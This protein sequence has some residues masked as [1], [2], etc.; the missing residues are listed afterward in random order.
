M[1]II[2]TTQDFI[3]WRSTVKQS[4][5]FVPTMGNLHEGHMSLLEASLQ[6]HPVSVLSVFV[7]PKQFNESSDFQRYPRT[8]EQD[9]ALCAALL[10]QHKGRDLVI[11]APADPSEIYPPG[12]ASVVSVPTLG[13][14]FEGEFRPGHFEGMATVVYLLLHT[15]RPQAAYFGRKDYQQYRIVKRM[16]RDLGLPVHI[17][18]MPI[19][20]AEDG[21]ALSSRNQFLKG[22]ERSEALKL[23][24]TLQHLAR[25]IAGSSA[26][27]ER[28]SAHAREVMSSDSR[29][30]YLAIR[31]ARHLSKDIPARGKL[32][33][34]GLLKVGSVRLLDNLEVEVT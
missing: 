34:L 23:P 29:W 17:K 11:Y 28:A 2:R 5:G 25:L 18:G 26:N 16:A 32:V 1:K 3:T 13:E 24:Q 9:A 20:R 21:L 15:V 33:I 10:G 6:E 7:N 19:I 31:E 22:D 4:I 14:E 12:F 8:L 27:V 30:Q